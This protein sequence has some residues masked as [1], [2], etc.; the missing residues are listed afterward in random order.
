[1]KLKIIG[2]ILVF[3][4]V[5]LFYQCKKSPE[6]LTDNSVD[7]PAQAC[8]I[9]ADVTETGQKIMEFNYNDKNQLTEIISNG[10]NSDGSLLYFNKRTIE[11]NNKN[12][13]VKVNYYKQNS[14]TEIEFYSEYEYDSQ[15]QLIA[16]HNFNSKNQFISHE[17][18]EYNIQGQL[19]KKII[20]GVNSSIGF[21]YDGNGDLIK[22]G[23]LNSE[24]VIIKSHMVVYEYDVSR[25]AFTVSASHS[26]IYGEDIIRSMFMYDFTHSI[27]FCKRVYMYGAFGEL[28]SD[29]NF[30]IEKSNAEGYPEIIVRYVNGDQNLKATYQYLYNCN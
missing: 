18:R 13:Q 27:H 1:M 12:Q 29:S 5:I 22:S 17:V 26:S 20:D 2:R 21:E 7:P 8:R 15:R 24:G 19:I 10:W 16:I 30:E 9:I 3:F 14:P 28:V 23:L 11:W 25:P 4:L 6:N